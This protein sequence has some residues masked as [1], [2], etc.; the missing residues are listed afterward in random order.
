MKTRNSHG[1]LQL[2]VGREALAYCQCLY[3]ENKAPFV[4]VDL[5]GEKNQVILE[6]L[7]YH[8]RKCHFKEIVD[9]YKVINEWRHDMHWQNTFFHYFLKTQIHSYNIRHKCRLS[10]EKRRHYCIFKWYHILY[11]NITKCNN[12]A[13]FIWYQ[14]TRGPKGH[15]SCTWVQCA[16]FLTDQPGRNFLFT[17]RLE[18]HKLG[19][20]PWDL[21]SCQV[22]LNSVQRF[23][24]RSRKC[25]SQSEARA[26]IL[27]FRSARK[28]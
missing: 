14:L 19:R 7:V 26:A 9:S 8:R 10:V 20:R 18:K 17:H 4:S 6:I 23:Q 5:I 15:I 16:S 22:S 28:T 3:R 12:F 13:Y 2:H 1:L 21:A 27:F 11:V 25:L 24:R